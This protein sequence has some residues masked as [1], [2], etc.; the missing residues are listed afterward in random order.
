MPTVDLSHEAHRLH[1]A[2]DIDRVTMPRQTRPDAPPPPPEQRQQLVR[3]VPHALTDQVGGAD[4]VAKVLCDHTTTV[5]SVFHWSNFASA[6]ATRRTL[7][8]A[9]SSS[10]DGTMPSN[11]QFDSSVTRALNGHRLLS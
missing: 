6:A 10:P 8:A 1:Q 7:E 5:H 2:R 4:R 9:R 3:V 11:D